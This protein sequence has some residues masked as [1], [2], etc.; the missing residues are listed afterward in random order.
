MDRKLNCYS[1]YLGKYSFFEFYKDLVDAGE[2]FNAVELFEDG[3]SIITDDTVFYGYRDLNSVTEI[4]IVIYYR[5]DFVK[6][7]K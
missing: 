7:V 5:V 2:S 1:N 6:E 4:F 3:F